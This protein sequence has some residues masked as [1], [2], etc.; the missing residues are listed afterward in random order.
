MENRILYSTALTIMAFSIMH[1]RKPDPIDAETLLGNQSRIIEV[2][3]GKIDFVASFI[4][5]EENPEVYVSLDIPPNSVSEKT[6]IQII[7]GDLFDIADLDYNV[8][9]GGR[10]TVICP[11]VVTN[12]D[13]DTS[14]VIWQWRA[15]VGFTP[16]LTS[17]RR[18]VRLTFRYLQ[19]QLN[20]FPDVNW[21][22]GHF[23]EFDAPQLFKVLLGPQLQM[24]LE[25]DRMIDF[26]IN[27]QSLWELVDPSKYVV[28]T[29]Q[30]TVSLNINNFN[31]LYFMAAE[32]RVLKR[33]EQVTIDLQ[34]GADRAQIAW[35]SDE[36]VQTS[37]PVIDIDDIKPLLPKTQKGLIK[38]DQYFDYGYLGR[39]ESTISN[40]LTDRY[41][42][43]FY[44]FRFRDVGSDGFHID[45]SDISIY[46][47]HREG[48][49]LLA[50]QK[51]TPPSENDLSLQID[52]IGAV[53]D[54]I[55]GELNGVFMD[56]DAQD[57]QVQIQFQI[58]RNH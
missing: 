32:R 8:I 10:D 20:R 49:F 58:V 53:G 37:N 28:D 1:C 22:D 17:F 57:Y 36:L 26:L 46:L 45:S 40:E 48:S 51:L 29:V 12:D 2:D 31:Y 15:M 50:S 11:V 35:A 38:S 27:H 34:R 13:L 41:N 23:F 9:N 54:R 19:P 30:S 16:N 6:L 42:E 21:V 14:I 56:E 39:F 18:P 52:Q 25:N 47:I 5:I 4:Q 7:R 55:I 3:G 33:D 24:S 44:H 43:V